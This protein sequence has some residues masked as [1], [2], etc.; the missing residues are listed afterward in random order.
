MN[1]REFLK[2][3]FTIAALG[4]VSTLLARTGLG[5]GGESGT[6]GN[7]SEKNGMIYRTLGRTGLRV[8]AIA[9]GVEGFQRRSRSEVRTLF[10]YA[11]DRGVNFLD[12]CVVDPEI[13]AGFGDVIR[14]KRDRFVI[15]GHIGSIWE[16]GQYRRT[17]DLAATKRAFESMLKNLGTD[18]IDVG[19]IHYVDDSGDYDRIFNGETIRYVKK[20]KAEKTVRHIGLSTHNPEIARRAIAGGLVDVLM[21]SVNLS[22]DADLAGNALTFNK[23]RQQLY[24]LCER[25]GIGLDVMKAYAGGNLL[26]DNSPFGMAFT[27]V[28]CLHYALTRP[29]VAAVMAGCRT[30]AEIDSALAWCTASAAER[31]YSKVLAGASRNT[32]TG[33]CLYCGHCA[34]CPKEIDIASVNKY[35]NLAL[36]QKEV[37]DT[38]RDHYRL[39]KHH[40]SECIQ[41]GA[42]EKRCPFG[43]PVRQKMKE[44]AKVFG[45]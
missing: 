14:K 10:Q 39:L 40:A 6:D 20:L 42:C 27:P 11:A 18:Y 35:L 21:F 26:T 28:Q 33:Y 44:A 25:R 2:G 37:P 5:A 30:P 24:E 36:A 19:M 22:Y 7:P 34:P 9:L 41:C 4:S 23:E 1:R 17:R 29:G 13:V 38:V 12:I 45:V 8:S 31:D 43:V 16:H 15:Q 32:W 3:A